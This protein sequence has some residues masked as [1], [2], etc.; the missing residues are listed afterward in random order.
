MEVL[1]HLPSKCKVMSSNSSNHPPPQKKFQRIL[2]RVCALYS[3]TDVWLTLLPM[4]PLVLQQALHEGFP[5][6]INIL[7]I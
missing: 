5:I 2:E 3:S 4:S 7:P 6:Y 1:K